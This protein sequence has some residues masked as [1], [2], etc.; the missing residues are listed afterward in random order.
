MLTGMG[1]VNSYMPPFAGTEEEKKAVAAWI[2]N[3][4]QGKMTIAKGPYPAEEL[5]LEIPPFDRD[6][7]QYV[8]LVWNDLGMHCIS[9]N[10]KY[11][12]FLP[13]AN[14]FNAQLFKR[15]PLPEVIKSGITMEYAVEEGF[16][17]PEQ[18]SLFWDYDQEIFGA[19]FP[20]GTGLAGKGV[21]GTMEPTG[22]VYAAHFI[23]VVPYMDNN[24]YNPYPIFTITA[25][26]ES[27]GEVLAVTKAVAPTSTEMGCRNCHEG[28]WRWNNVSGMA[29]MTAS[30]ILKAH[31]KYNGTTLLADAERG[32]PKLCQS[33]HADPALM[34][35]GKP[36]VLNF[37]T[38]M[39]GFHANYLSGMDQEACNMC[40]PSR[41]EGNT[42][43]FRGRHSEIGLGCT[44]CHGT[45]EDHALSLLAT[46]P[47]IAAAQRLSRGLEPVF[48]A[49]K[50]EIKPR[51]PW[52]ME[53]DC[54][55]CH[56][57]YSIF[58]DGFCRDCV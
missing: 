22:S 40:H 53:P 7:S 9:D 46:Q 44:E 37:S 24:M 13:P 20:E 4:I 25:R 41:P 48:A 15:G 5:P 33:C 2:Y 19:D 8:L 57:N 3:E 38:A 45:L 32:E 35:P 52:L 55:S 6:T 30:N 23:P 10:E 26:D 14:T 21:S 16:L 43:C 31:D 51:M 42:N 1:K 34:A 56:T 29:D 47:G 27:T 18:H 50:E 28:E 11:F 49:S 58:E 36:G 17:H 12:S 39:H 54:R